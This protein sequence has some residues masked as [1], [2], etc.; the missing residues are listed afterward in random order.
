MKVYVDELPECCNECP[1]CNNDVD[2]GSCCNL[3]AYEYEDYYQTIYKHPRCPLQSL[4]DHDKQV[5]KQVCDEI[6]RKIT[7]IA[8]RHPNHNIGFDCEDIQISCLEITSV[9]DQIQ[10]ENND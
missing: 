9:L 2:Y 3:G 5:R 1:C 4:A 10:G 8:K 7:M 6:G